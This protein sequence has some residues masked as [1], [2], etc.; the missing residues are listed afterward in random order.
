MTARRR[1]PAKDPEN[2]PALYSADAEFGLLGTILQPQ[3]SLDLEYAARALRPE[4]F[5]DAANRTIFSACLELRAQGT[6]ADPR[7]LRVLLDERHLL[8]ALDTKGGSEYLLRLVDGVATG[9]QIPYYCRVI[10]K[11]AKAR[12][13]IDIVS[14][15]TAQA[16]ANGCNLDVLYSRLLDE[17]EELHAAGDGPSEAGDLTCG[18]DAFLG[19]PPPLQWDVASVRVQGDH[20]WT[21][22]APKSM[23]GYISLEEAR[24]NATGTL[25]LGR[26]SARKCRVLYVSEEDRPARLHRRFHALVSGRP[27]EEIPG[28]DALRFLIKTGVRLDTAEG[29]ALLRD[30]LVRWHPD[31]VFLEHFDKLHSKNPSKAE[32]VKPLLDM[33]DELHRD[34]H[35]VF[36]VQKHFR[37]QQAGQ[38]KRTGEMLAGAQGL[39][40][41]GESSIYVTL[42]KRGLAQVECDAKDGDVA[43]RFLVRYEAGKLV[44]AGEVQADRLDGQRQA[45]LEFLEA[46]PGATRDEVAAAVKVSGRTAGTYLR[47]MEKDGLVVGKSLVSKQPKQWWVKGAETQEELLGK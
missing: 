24:A 36:R 34:H 8:A 23:K 4:H 38:G 1:A 5:Y 42:I 20:G 37:K 9:A 29:T 17:L 40:G 35:C 39:F 25:F 11:K 43:N 3:F 33:L 6:P 30:H 31:V 15:F 47:G 19:D 32:E 14:R 18:A 12:R 26:F 41:W 44:Y 2:I 10:R 45:V 13:A 22:G 7:S 27:T 21:G 16:G 46:S 28:P